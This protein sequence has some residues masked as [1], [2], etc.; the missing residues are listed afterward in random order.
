M[1]KE[2]EAS[3][4]PCWMLILLLTAGHGAW[5]WVL[6]VGALYIVATEL[7]YRHA[8]TASRRSGFKRM[9]RMPAPAWLLR[10]I[11]WRRMEIPR[12]AKCYTL[13]VH[14]YA[15]PRQLIRELKA[16]IER[17]RGEPAVYIGN[18]FYD[19]GEY[20]RRVLGA[21]RVQ[22]IDGALFGRWLQ[23]WKAPEKPWR[24]VKISIEK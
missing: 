9:V 18:T 8:V 3:I 14:G 19:L 10:L 12:G 4:L 11:L 2:L 7:Y 5:H 20:A 13:H 15:P 16:D 21:E 23:T 22:V 17:G 1:L 6:T 24:I